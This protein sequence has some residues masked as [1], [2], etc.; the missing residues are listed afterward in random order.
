MI[1]T[2]L[3][4]LI[5]K[6]GYDNFWEVFDFLILASY[7]EIESLKIASDMFNGKIWDGVIVATV[8]EAYNVNISGTAANASNARTGSVLI[9][10]S[11]GQHYWSNGDVLLQISL[12]TKYANKNYVELYKH[13]I[14]TKQYAEI[15]DFED[16]IKTVSVKLTTELG[17]SL[18]KEFALK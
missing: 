2:E 9:T 6:R 17:V 14:K 16:H 8:E 7:E 13:Y 11:N 1:D 5:N 3:V 10:D 4:S 15:K 12:M 18:V